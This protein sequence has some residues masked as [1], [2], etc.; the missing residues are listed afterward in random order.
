MRSIVG[1]DTPISN[2]QL[3]RIDVPLETVGLATLP[4]ATLVVWSTRPCACWR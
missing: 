1:C 4:L 3:A 2:D